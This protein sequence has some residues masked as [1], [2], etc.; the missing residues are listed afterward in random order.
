MRML[1]FMGIKTIFGPYGMDFDSG[2]S[3]SVGR[4]NKLS[5]LN[6]FFLTKHFVK[7]IL[8]KLFYRSR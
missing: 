3:M 5:S 7:S 6:L 2:F 8:A 4:V 1:F